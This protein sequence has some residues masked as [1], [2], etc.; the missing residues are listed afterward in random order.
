MASDQTANVALVLWLQL[1]GVL[2]GGVVWARRAWGTRQAT[3]IGAPLVVATVWNIYSTV[4][5][6][7]PNLL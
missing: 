2:L 6:L 3:L 1:L 4:A 5:H 7:L